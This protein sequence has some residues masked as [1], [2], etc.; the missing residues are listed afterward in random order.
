MSWIEDFKQVRSAHRL[1][2]DAETRTRQALD[3]NPS[4]SERRRLNS[5]L[6]ELGIA[7][8]KLASRRTAIIRE[9]RAIV[10]P[11]NEQVNRI[12]TLTMEV[13]N[14]TNAAMAASMTLDFAGRV[15]D[16]AN[17]LVG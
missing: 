9:R 11:T 2:I 10:N 3:R 8:S 4:V 6:V 15:L 5:D 1:V 17:E 16:L 7:Q 13:Q 12:K 14:Q